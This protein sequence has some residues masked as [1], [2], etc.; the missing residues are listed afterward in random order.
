MPHA[1]RRGALVLL[2]LALSAATVGAIALAGVSVTMA[3]SYPRSATAVPPWGWPA[4]RSAPPSAI[5]VAVVV[6]E[7]GSVIS[8][9]LLPYEVFARSSRFFVYTVSTRREPTPLSGGLR[10]VPDHTFADVDAGRAPAPDV[11]VIPALADPAS[12]RRAPLH[13]W[14]TR[15]AGR[16]AYLLGVCYGAKVLADSGL[17]DGRRATSFWRR[18][19]SL[20]GE[21]PGVRWVAG[22]RYVQDGRII[23]TAGITSGLVGALRLVELLAG[24]AEADRMGSALAYPGWSLD[25]STGIAEN[26]LVLSD[27]P[28]A[29]NA[30][31]PWL[32]PTVAVG[33]VDGV[34][35]LDVA[36]VAEAYDGS[37]F[38]AR[39]AAI[40]A[41]PTVTTRHGLLLV[42]EPAD[43]TTRRPDRLVVPGVERP[44]PVLADWAARRDLDPVLP[45]A[46]RVPGEFSFDPVLRDLAAHAD[47]ATARTTAKFTEYPGEHLRLTGDA[48]PWRA[49]LLCAATL[50]LAVGAGLL[51]AAA[52]RRARRRSTATRRESSRSPRL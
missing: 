21:H 11:V 7:T 45:H 28:Y 10:V 42:A 51:P 19:G 40:A 36:A 25:A 14:L 27:L 34:G 41:G 9:A 3:Q 5:V 30:A 13:S 35:E 38:T 39:I 46:G 22:Q 1:L 26:R 48:W 50:I 43:A 2:G 52:A 23:T 49:T 37:S 24:R 17:L 20:R 29:L 33:L 16:G 15:H 32:R 47:R 44:D 31:F 18:L 4:P 8:D 12:A 6:G